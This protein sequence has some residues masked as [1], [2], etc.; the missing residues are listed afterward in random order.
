MRAIV[1]EAYGPPEALVCR[2]VDEPFPQPGEVVVDIE[3]CAVNFPDVLMIQGLYQVKP[4]LPFVPG[5]EIAGT[6]RALGEGVQDLAVGDRVFG[7]AGRGGLAERAA[8]PASV[9]V[10]LPPSADLVH[11]AGFL[12]A[13]GTSY[14]ALSARAHLEPGE[15]LL[16]L[17]AAGGVGLAAVELGALMGARV[18]AGASSPE[19]LAIC[20]AHGAELAIDYQREDLRGRLRELTDG[21]GVDVVFDPIGGDLSEPAL[22]STGWGG[23][24]L[25]IGFASGDIPKLPINLTLLKG[26]SIVGVYWGASVARDPEGSRANTATLV[27]WWLEGKLRPFVSSTYALDRAPDALRELLERRATGRVVVTTGPSAPP[28]PSHP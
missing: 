14:Y 18:I 27:D 15:T 6:V 8:A 23:R 20:R 12:Y 21:S 19:K 17:G 4:P 26:S 2:E 24:F 1:C 11:A 9:L 5:G 22:R 28:S 10:P 3:A 13:Y 25:V 16:V 7:V